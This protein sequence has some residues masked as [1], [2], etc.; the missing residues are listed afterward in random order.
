MLPDATNRSALRWLRLLASGLLATTLGACSTAGYLLQAAHGEARLL[1]RR[2]PL[3]QVIADPA[4]PAALRTQLE[5]VRAAR[6][7]AVRSL[8]LPD[9]A[10]YRSYADI[11][12]PYVVWNV[13]AAPEFAVEPRRWCFPF[14]GCVAY[15]GYFREA[16][17][18]RYAERLARRGDD[19]LV[20]GVS[21]YST[22]GHFNDPVVSSMLRQGE[23]TLV[24]TL[25]H[26]L[27]HQQLYLP[28]DTE[29]N[30]AF[31]MTVE[32]EGL[33]RWLAARG[34]PAELEGFLA[35][36]RRQAALAAILAGARHELAGLYAS[37]LPAAELRTRKQARLEQAGREL[38]DYARAEGGA[39][40]YEPWIAA[41]LNNAHLAAV[42][43]YQGCIPGFQRLLAEAGGD[44]PRF[45]AAARALARGPAAARRALCVAAAE[46]VTT[47]AMPAM[48]ATA[49]DGAAGLTSPRPGP[50]SAPPPAASG[51]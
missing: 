12:R 7:F 1:A 40:G 46:P 20:A 25:F 44:L 45:Y 31:A 22:L 16:N 50:A 51:S 36:R 19:V 2:R 8:A 10:S 27:A 41:G 3:G 15:R 28:G 43:S 17:A 9:N 48:P 30:E 18:R 38:Q 37:D 24:A 35:Q 47:P 11:G 5:T 32:Q 29:F 6:E 42:A 13:I 23:N 26:E 34:R 14:T 39:S 33:A 21:A 4:T 49:A